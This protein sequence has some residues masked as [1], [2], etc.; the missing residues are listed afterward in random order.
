MEKRFPKAN[1]SYVQLRDMSVCGGDLNVV[2][3]GLFSVENPIWKKITESRKHPLR[4]VSFLG[5]DNLIL[6]ALHLYSLETAV[7]RISKKLK[8][9]A[10][11]LVCPY[12]EMAM[13]ADK[14]HQLAILRQDLELSK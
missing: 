1:R 8:I 9:N 7:K 13:D 5:L 2:D 14:P 11:A 10:R 3:T 4:Q 6:V 12:A